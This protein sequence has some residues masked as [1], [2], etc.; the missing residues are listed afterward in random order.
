M[1]GSARHESKIKN[2]G[3]RK[4]LSDARGEKMKTKVA[5]LK[6]CAY[7]MNLAQKTDEQS[8]LINAI[9]NCLDE[10]AEAIDNNTED[11]ED[12]SEELEVVSES[13][14]II[15]EILDEMVDDDDDDDNE[16]GKR[17][18]LDWLDEDEFVNDGETI[19]ADE[20]DDDDEDEDVSWL[21]PE[22]RKYIDGL[23]KKEENGNGGEKD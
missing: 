20:N 16:E 7:G 4:G 13:V 23:L 14:D 3:I 12:I 18:F 11:I 21:D 6:G 15:D 8:K 1:S 19:D 17:D 22:L 2:F 5:F 10:M 9:I